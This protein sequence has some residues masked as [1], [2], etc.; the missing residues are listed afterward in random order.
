MTV[1]STH[2]NNTPISKVL[3]KGDVFGFPIVLIHFL[4]NIGHTPA[5]AIS[6]LSSCNPSSIT[7]SNSAFGS[8]PPFSVK[9]LAK[10]I[11]VDKKVN[12]YLQ[13][14]FWVDP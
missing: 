11:Q 9:I 8:N 14:Q 4:A 3:N 10:V 7:I 13:A 2:N 1:L 12:D 5:T 6:G